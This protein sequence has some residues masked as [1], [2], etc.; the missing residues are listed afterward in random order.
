MNRR[1]TEAYEAVYDFVNSKVLELAGAKLFITDYE[2][3]MRNALKK[4]YPIA[5]FTACHFH[6][7]QAVRKNAMSINGFMKFIEQNDL[8]KRTYYKLIYLPLLPPGQIDIIFNTVI[9]DDVEAIGDAKFDKLFKYYRRQWMRKEG[10][11]KISVFGKETRTTS[12]AEGFNR[13]LNAYCQKKGSFVWFCS[14]I[15]NQEFMKSKE[16]ATF[17]H[18]GGIEGWN[19]KKRGQ[20]EQ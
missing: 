10:A 5:K 19:Q 4:K 20:G 2:L 16:F 14:N 3:A 9:T 6:F 13:A 17:V 18:S 15:R 11:R 7:A 1:T 8:A 12:P